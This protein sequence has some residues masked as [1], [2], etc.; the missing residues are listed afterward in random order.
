MV[1]AVGNTATYEQAFRMVRD[2]GTVS[3]F[4]I[5]GD[6]DT[7]PLRTFDL[8]LHEK[9]VTGSCAGVGNDWTDALTLIEHGE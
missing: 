5:T 6:K 3:A 4:G 8:V 7:M 9:K 2:G 1:E